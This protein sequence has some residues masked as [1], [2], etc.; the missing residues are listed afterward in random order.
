MGTESHV[1]AGVRGH[2]DLPHRRRQDG[3]CRHDR[4]RDE[5]LSQRDCDQRL[6]GEAQRAAA[7]GFFHARGQETESVEEA[8]VVLRLIFPRAA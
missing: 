2:A 4:G 8:P 7:K 5:L 3:H 1:D 6:L